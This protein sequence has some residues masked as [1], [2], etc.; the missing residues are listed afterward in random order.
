MVGVQ[1]YRYDLT[2]RS[3]DEVCIMTQA[4]TA[5]LFGKGPALVVREARQPREPMK[6][7]KKAK[8]QAVLD[9]INPAGVYVN[10]D[11]K[12]MPYR[13]SAILP[14]TERKVGKKTKSDWRKSTFFKNLDVALFAARAQELY[15]NADPKAWMLDEEAAQASPELAEWAGNEVNADLVQFMQSLEPLADDGTDPNLGKYG[16]GSKIAGKGAGNDDADE[17]ESDL[18]A[19]LAKLMG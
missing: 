7:S 3:Y 17:D 14:G 8:Y 12:Y 5:A 2:Y 19:L 10:A 1:L 4:T 13:V 11:N 16:L 6:A 9:K 18:D 15:Y